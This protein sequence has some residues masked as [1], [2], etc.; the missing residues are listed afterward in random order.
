MKEITFL[1]LFSVNYP[2][3][4]ADSLIFRVLK[5]KTGTGETPRIFLRIN[6]LSIMLFEG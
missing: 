3:Y 5:M 1:F 6:K 4:S 2:F